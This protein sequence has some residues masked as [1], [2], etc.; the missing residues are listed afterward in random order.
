MAA[1]SLAVAVYHFRRPTR[2]GMLGALANRIADLERQ[3]SALQSELSI[4]RSEK[5]R[6]QDENLRL[7]REL[8]AAQ[9]GL[10]E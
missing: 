9:L 10:K 4:E 3:V 7:M 6:L 5:S 2:D 8:F 1:C